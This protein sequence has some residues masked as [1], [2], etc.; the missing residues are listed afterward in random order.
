[1]TKQEFIDGFTF[2]FRGKN[3]FFHNKTSNILLID[4][5]LGHLKIGE[6]YKMTDDSLEIEHILGHTTG[7]F[8]DYIIIPK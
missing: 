1:M 4:R 8:A 3:F 6:V 5:D 2:R 7:Y